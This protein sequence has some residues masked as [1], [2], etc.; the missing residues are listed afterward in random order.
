MMMLRPPDAA[1]HPSVDIV[2]RPHA[3]HINRAMPAFP[4]WKHVF[5]HYCTSVAFDKADQ[6]VGAPFIQSLHNQP[7]AAGHPPIQPPKHVASCWGNRMYP[8]LLQTQRAPLASVRRYSLS[9]SRSDTRCGTISGW[10]GTLISEERGVSHPAAFR[11]TC[12]KRDGNRC[13]MLECTRTPS[14]PNVDGL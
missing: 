13:S 5:A 1:T 8:S 2:H 10:R 9:D 7:G 3:H 12:H 4:A 11:P 6:Q 14:Q